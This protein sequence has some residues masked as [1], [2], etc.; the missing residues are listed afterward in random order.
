MTAPSDESLRVRGCC[1]ECY[2]DD[3]EGCIAGDWYERTQPERSLI[4]LTS[5]HRRTATSISEGCAGTCSSR[6]V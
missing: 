3:E 4:T 5:G 1:A 2:G 6:A